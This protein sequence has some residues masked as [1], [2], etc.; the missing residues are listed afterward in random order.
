MKIVKRE[1]VNELPNARRRRQA[2]T[3]MTSTHTHCILFID[4]LL[5][6]QS[7]KKTKRYRVVLLPI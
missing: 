1:C 7:H 3:R 4:C 5:A 6:T 2:G